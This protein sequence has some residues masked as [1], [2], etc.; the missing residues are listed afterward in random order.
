MYAAINIT[1]YGRVCNYNS[2]SVFDV[3]TSYV[4]YYRELDVDLSFSFGWTSGVGV[5]VTIGLEEYANQYYGRCQVRYN[6]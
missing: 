2:A 6:P 5:S 3:Y 4:D 1:G